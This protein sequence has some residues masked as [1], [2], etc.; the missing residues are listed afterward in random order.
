MDDVKEDLVSNLR[1]VEQNSTLKE[2]FSDIFMQLHNEIEQKYEKLEQRVLGELPQRYEMFS[3]YTTVL[4]RRYLGVGHA[5]L[6]PVVSEEAQEKKLDTGELIK[7][8]CSNEQPVIETV[9]CEADYLRCRQLDLDRPVLDGAFVINTVRYPFKCWLKR[10]KRYAEQIQV[11]HTAFLRNNIPWSTINSTYHNKF[12]DV[13]LIEPANIPIGTKILPEQIDID[14]GP[15]TD[16]V[17]R[18]LI[19]VWNVDKYRVLSDD[20]PVPVVDTVHYEYRFDLDRFGKDCGFL[21]D[22]DNIFILDSRQDERNLVITSS[23]NKDL[24]WYL[25][26]LRPRQDSAMDVFPYPVLTNAKKETIAAQLMI[27]SNRIIACKD[28]LREIVEIYVDSRYVL[29]GDLFFS[30]SSVT[31]ETYDMNPFI[32][33]EV[34]DPAFRRTLVFAFYADNRDLFYIRDIISF[35]VSVMQMVYPDYRC[36]GVLL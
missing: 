9:F 29:L 13:C 34:R 10:A 8:L 21:V 16:V 28:E 23:M 27:E 33:D 2:V 30:G 36:V 19:P 15:Y 31:G 20:N 7:A 5:Y 26:R 18:Q 22:H 12:Y 3:V 25:F 1:S 14:F 6:S 17:H 4:P 11:L 24:Q 35:L 32:R